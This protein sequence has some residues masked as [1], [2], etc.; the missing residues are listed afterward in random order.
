MVRETQRGFKNLSRRPVL[1]RE[2][3]DVMSRPTLAI[4]LHYAPQ[5][6]NLSSN[7]SLVVVNLLVAMQPQYSVNSVRRPYLLTPLWSG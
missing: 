5:S 1:D 3:K 7:A 2:K 4:A 6:S